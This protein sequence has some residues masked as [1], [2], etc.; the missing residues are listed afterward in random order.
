MIGQ[1]NIGQEDMQSAGPVLGRKRGFGRARS[2]E[3]VLG[4]KRGFGRARGTRPLLGRKWDFG[5]ER[6]H[7]LSVHIASASRTRRCDCFPGKTAEGPGRRG[8]ALP[9]WYM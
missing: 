3:P 9:L 2:T 7:R 4:R 1:G 8:N 6:A 5:C